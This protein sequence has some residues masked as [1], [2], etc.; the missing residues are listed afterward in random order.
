[1]CFRKKIPLHFLKML[2]FLVQVYCSC[3]VIETCLSLTFDRRYIAEK[4]P[5]QRKTPF[6]QS[7]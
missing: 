6:S 4:L 7:I 3:F 2:D 5:I 1:M